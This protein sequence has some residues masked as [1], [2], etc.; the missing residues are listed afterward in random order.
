MSGTKPIDRFLAIL[1]V[2][3]SVSGVAAS[4]ELSVVLDSNSILRG[5][6]VTGYVEIVG[7]V[8]SDFDRSIGFLSGSLWYEVSPVDEEPR[9]LDCRAIRFCVGTLRAGGDR[10]DDT[11]VN[12]IPLFVWF[13]DHEAVF[14][15]VGQYIFTVVVRHRNVDYRATETVNVDDHPDYRII[16][17]GLAGL[18]GDS[19][20]GLFAFDPP[21]RVP[22]RVFAGLSPDSPYADLVRVAVPFFESS[23]WGLKY[24]LNYSYYHGR[25]VEQPARDRLL[26]VDE[27]ARVSGKYRLIDAYVANAAAYLSGDAGGSGTP[28]RYWF[29]G[30]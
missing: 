9:V 12:R 13:I 22:P 1:W 24:V 5:E 19:A 30:S 26:R 4:E 2:V 15:E 18:K 11:I 8:P 21:T 20:F 23:G 7:D 6:P 28:E 27:L 16:E 17:R 3:V 14:S 25:D 29:C 10:I